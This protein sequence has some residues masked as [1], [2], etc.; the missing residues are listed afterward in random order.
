VRLWRKG[1]IDGGKYLVQRRDG[2]IP[3]WPAFVLGGRD[4]CAPA[5]LR[6]YAHAAAM[7]GLDPEFVQDVRELADEFEEY[8]RNHGAGDPDGK[9]HRKDDPETVAKILLGNSA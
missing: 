3:D 2:T 9:P 1:G 4:P 8:R 6:A 5:A 7:N